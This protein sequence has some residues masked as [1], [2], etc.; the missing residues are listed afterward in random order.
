MLTRSRVSEMQQKAAKES[1]AGK[2]FAGN[3]SN[4]Y[5]TLSFEEVLSMCQRYI[6]NAATNAFRR[7]NDL[8]SSA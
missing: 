6:T 8:L 4:R 5:V 2:E 1:T 7:E 3:A